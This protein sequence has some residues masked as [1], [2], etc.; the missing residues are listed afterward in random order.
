MS[1]W[2]EGESRIDCDIDRV[3]SAVAD[4]GAMI[5]GVVGQMP[6]MTEV[7][8]VEEGPDW[9]TLRTN[10]GLMKRT[11]ITKR[12]EPDTVVVECNEEYQAGSRVSAT[13]HF[14]NEFTTSGAGVVHRTVVSD[15]QASGLLGFFYRRFG[16][17][18]MGKAFLS[19][20][21]GYLEL[22]PSTD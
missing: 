17:R 12:V 10:E 15:V 8:L 14:R 19:S 2:F 9:V 7:E 3:K 21:K 18:S 11:G 4:Y 13:S 5:A 6:G 16:S 20:Y 22:V 1:V